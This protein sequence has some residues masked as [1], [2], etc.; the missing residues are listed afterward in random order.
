MPSA[1]TTSVGM[2][3]TNQHG[4]GELRL[5]LS[6]KIIHAWGACREPKLCLDPYTLPTV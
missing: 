5:E 4:K 2:P 6:R 3:A 1:G